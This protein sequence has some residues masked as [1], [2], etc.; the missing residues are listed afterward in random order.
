MS[1]VTTVTAVSTV[2]SVSTVMLRAVILT[3]DVNRM[4]W[5]VVDTVLRMEW[6]I[7]AEAMRMNL[8]TIAELLGMHLFAI[9][10]V[11]SMGLFTVIKTVKKIMTC[12]RLVIT[13][14]LTVDDLMAMFFLQ[15]MFLAIA[16]ISSI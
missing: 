1:W 11:F 16:V 10:D 12:R 2:S 7:V 15:T 8:F 6:F 4:S 13:I 9:A 5:L 3:M 14:V